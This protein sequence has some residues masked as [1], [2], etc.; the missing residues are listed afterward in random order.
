[1]R[2]RHLTGVVAG[3]ALAAPTAVVATPALADGTTS[4]VV[5]VYNDTNCCGAVT[6]ASVEL[7]STTTG[8][9]VGT[10]AATDDWG[11]AGF[12]VPAGSYTAKVTKPGFYTEYTT[13]STV[14][15]E[16]VAT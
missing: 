12:S 11:S 6:G 9:K 15:A 3:L 1:M 5:S 2:R 4:F 8:A 13:V 14:T 7:Y 16:D 10:A